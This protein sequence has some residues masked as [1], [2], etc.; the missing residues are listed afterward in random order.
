VRPHAIACD[1]VARRLVDDDGSERMVP[2]DASEARAAYRIE[3]G[4]R[5][6]LDL[7]RDVEQRRDLLAAYQPAPL[8][9]RVSRAFRLAES[10]VRARFLEPTLPLVV[11]GPEAL[12]K[13]AAAMSPSS[14][15]S[16][17]PR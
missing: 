4:S 8:P 7:I 17:R 10:M 15:R 11:T 16:A 14:S 13:A 2:P 12:L 5:G 9:A 6:W 1:Y 3:D